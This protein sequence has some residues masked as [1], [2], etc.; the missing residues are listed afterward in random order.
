MAKVARTK[1]KD[2]WKNKMWYRLH[3]PSMFNYTIMAHTPAENP[4]F[5]N[6]RVA[7]VP[8]EKLTGDYTQKNFMIKFR[9]TDGVFSYKLK[10]VIVS[11]GS[12]NTM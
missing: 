10:I 4:D 2:K 3:A 11:C 12:Y 5:V 7:E 6:G 8:L 1:V 9:T